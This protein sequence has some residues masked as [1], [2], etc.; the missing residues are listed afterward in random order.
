MWSAIVNY[1]Q[2]DTMKILPRIAAADRA[3]ISISTLKRLEVDG[4]FPGKVQMTPGRVGYVEA[5]VDGWISERI[6]E[7]DTIK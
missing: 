2:M 1:R 6:A 3:G 7:R 5:E 4:D